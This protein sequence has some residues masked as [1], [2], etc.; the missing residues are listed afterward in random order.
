MARI[1]SEK[2]AFCFY[3]GEN[4]HENNT[5]VKNDGVMVSLYLHGNRIAFYPVKLKKKVCFTLAGWNT[6]TTRERLKALGIEIRVKN[7]IPFYDG[8]EIDPDD[9]YY[10]N[11]IA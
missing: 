11:I 2:A 9:T 6:N 3:R 10:T 8:K 4:F 1:I 5:R 7:G